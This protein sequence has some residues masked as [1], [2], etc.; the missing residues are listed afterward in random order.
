M[1]EEFSKYLSYDIISMLSMHWS[2]ANVAAIEEEDERAIMPPPSSAEGSPSRLHSQTVMRAPLAKL[3]TQTGSRGD[4][5]ITTS[6]F[7]CTGMFHWQPDANIES[8]ILV[9]SYVPYLPSRKFYK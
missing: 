5:E 1:N 8:A 3:E 7:D 9:Y 2:R 4:E 6:E